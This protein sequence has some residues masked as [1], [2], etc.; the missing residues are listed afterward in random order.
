MTTGLSNQL[1]AE[2]R[3]RLTDVCD[4]AGIPA[5]NATLIKYT[6]NAV[7]RTG[8]YI[9][10]LAHGD[11]ARTLAQRTT[12]LA[13]ELARRDIPTI[14]LATDL[15][16]QP[17]HTQNWVATI[18]QY[19]PTAH[20]DPWPVDLA[21]PLHALHTVNRFDTPLPAWNPITKIHRRIT[22]ATTL[23]DTTATKTD[24]WSRTQLGMPA[25]QLLHTLRDW[26]HDIDQQLPEIRWHLPAGPIHGDA[27][28]GNLLLRR[29]PDRPAPDPT[30][31]LCDLDAISHGPREWDLVPT[32]HGTTRFGRSREAYDAFA[33]AY[34]FDILT[35]SG[36]PLIA[37]L[38][39][40]QLVT[41]VIDSFTD[42][43]TIADELA[44]RLRSLLA[45]NPTVV[46][47][48]YH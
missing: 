24:Q 47:T 16:P 41:S 13:A 44:H 30:A 17:V 4:H 46:W 25:T 11:H 19:V 31:L 27:H 35:W 9:I 14:R 7:F 43:P 22:N 1:E 38:R 20:D 48:R 2:L 28:T 45:N 3:N 33:D 42:R 37:R 5:N 39:E 36:W 8:D 26:C 40:L 32:A 12:A 18:W 29:V 21:A 23:P 10:R 6:M 15:A 34:D